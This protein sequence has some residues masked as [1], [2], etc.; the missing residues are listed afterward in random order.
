MKVW[1]SLPDLLY[2]GQASF[3][4]Q[5]ILRISDSFFILCCYLYRKFK[6]H[7]LSYSSCACVKPFSVPGCYA[8]CTDEVLPTL[9]IFLFTQAGRTHRSAIL[10]QAFLV[11]KNWPFFFFVRLSTFPTYHRMTSS[12]LTIWKPRDFHEELLR[13]LWQHRGEE[14]RRS[15]NSPC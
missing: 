12:S 10:N 11:N 4:D 3:T 1:H 14:F 6:F 13:L 7:Y 9:W 5:T 8:Q 2:F 15:T